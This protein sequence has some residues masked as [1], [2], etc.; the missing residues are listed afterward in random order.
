ML[1]R[2]DLLKPFRSRIKTQALARWRSAWLMAFS[3]RSMNN[4]RLGRPVSGSCRASCSAIA[5]LTAA[6]RPTK[7]MT[8]IVDIS[9]IA[10]TTLTWPGIAAAKRAA[11]PATTTTAIS[12]GESTAAATATGTTLRAPGLTLR[13]LK[14]SASRINASET[15]QTAVIQSPPRPRAELRSR[16]YAVRPTLRAIAER[17]PVV[18]GGADLFALEAEKRGPR[19]GLGFT[20][21]D[22]CAGEWPVSGRRRH[23][24][25]KTGPMPRSDRGGSD[26]PPW[27]LPKSG[28]DEAIPVQSKTTG[29][30]LSLMGARVSLSHLDLMIVV[31]SKGQSPSTCLDVWMSDHAVAPETAEQVCLS[32]SLVLMQAARSASFSN[33]A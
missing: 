24:V 30:S 29:S 25:G 10:L 28:C 18:V 11:K 31:K 27:S 8:S 19:L 14:R 20:M 13:G 7:A 1:F 32:E 22:Y 4:R 3:S 9:A 6:S 17:I 15:R 21:L 33:R 16:E 12:R 5:K 2:S 23:F 26:V